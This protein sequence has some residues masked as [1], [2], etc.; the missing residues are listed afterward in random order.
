VTRVGET[1]CGDGG[2]RSEDEG[3]GTLDSMTS[4]GST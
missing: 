2:R 4:R 3:D 1:I